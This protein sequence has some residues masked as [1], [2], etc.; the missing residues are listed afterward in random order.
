MKSTKTLIIILMAFSFLNAPA[1][2]RLHEISIHHGF[3][4][5]DEVELGCENLLD[6]I[7]SNIFCSES[8]ITKLNFTGPIG[9]SFQSRFDN[10]GYGASFYYLRGK[11]TS[12][13]YRKDVSIY[14]T[15]YD[16]KYYWIT[17]D[18]LK[19]SSGISLGLTLKNDKE[20]DINKSPHTDENNAIRLAYQFDL[21]S[22]QLGRN[23]TFDMDLGV[24]RKGSFVMGLG[25]Q[26]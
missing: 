22:L 25:Y 17:N 19:L 6:N 8:S 1:Q 18:Y 14:N 16:L 26:F 23:V 15:F 7:F 11:R 21:L 2:E 10:F 4:S 13:D 12:S 3:W 24:G 5:I 20:W 9:V